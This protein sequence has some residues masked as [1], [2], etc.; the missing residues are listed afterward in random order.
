LFGALALTFLITTPLPAQKV[1]TSFD[2]STDFTRYKRYALGKNYLLTH[3]RPEDQARIEKA[4]TESLN[5]QLQGKGFV[6]DEKNPDF[7]ITYDAGALTGGDASARPDM[8]NGGAPGPSFS[9]DSLGGTT[10]DVWTSTLAKMK[11]TVTDSSSGQ[12]VWQAFVS[13]K[14]S[15]PQKFLNDL[16]KNL[17]Q[18][19]SKALKNFP[20]P[21]KR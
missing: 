7:R 13:K 19:M 3:Q 21:S 15:D 17:D 16:S 12:P 6:L 4:I 18:V 20:P 2:K 5:H 11:L 14:V 9:S 1:K 10:M 8:L